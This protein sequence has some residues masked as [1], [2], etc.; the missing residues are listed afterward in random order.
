M[1]SIRLAFVVSISAISVV[2]FAGLFFLSSTGSSLFGQGDKSSELLRS[3][4]LSVT[5]R[6]G[7]AEKSVIQLRIELGLF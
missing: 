7:N 2:L 5:R 3:N 4:M 1:S 6:I